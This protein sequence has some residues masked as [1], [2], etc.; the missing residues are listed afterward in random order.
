[1]ENIFHFWRSG[2]KEYVK[3]H[4]PEEVYEQVVNTGEYFDGMSKAFKC[5]FSLAQNNPKK[6]IAWNE[7]KLAKEIS[8]LK[9]VN[10]RDK[11]RVRLMIRIYQLIYKKYFPQYMDL[12]GDLESVYL[13]SKADI[14]ALRRAL[15]ANTHYN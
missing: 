4:L 2:N 3:K 10:K 12:L 14:S 6:F 13:F 5:L 8:E 1:M 7:A 15:S 11:E 9:E